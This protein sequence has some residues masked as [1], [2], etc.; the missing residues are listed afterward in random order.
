MSEVDP[1][2]V[3]ARIERQ[4]MWQHAHDKSLLR[5]LETGVLK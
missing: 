4:T 1:T 2:H 5:L 3:Y